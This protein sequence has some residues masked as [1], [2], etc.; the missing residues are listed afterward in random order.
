VAAEDRIGLS[1]VAEL[2]EVSRATAAKYVNRPDFPKPAQVA[3][4][5]RLWLPSEVKAW[6][7]RT[8]PLPE[9]QA[10]RRQR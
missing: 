7:G 3:R 4:R 1:E 8:L 5:G 10:A 2:L 9:G 6:A